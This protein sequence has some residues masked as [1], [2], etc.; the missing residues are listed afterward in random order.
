MPESQISDAQLLQSYVGGDTAAFAELMDRY[1]QPLFNWLVGMTSSRADAED[2]YQEVWLR[3]IN[4]ATR[5][6]NISF[7]AW[8]WRIARNLLIDFRRKRKPD[9]SLDAVDEPD[10][11]PLV[12]L[13]VSQA[14][15]PDKRAELQDAALRAMRAV[16]RLPA[17]QREVFLMRV[18]GDMSFKEIAESLE[19][20]LNTA[21]GRMHDA[22]NKLRRALGEEV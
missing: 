16:E 20:P 2:L 21:L 15:G 11:K 19:I 5:F 13:L 14:H 3:V 1:R 10:G 17:M 9:L 12:E 18:E 7:R 6:T 22:V 8:L 4:N